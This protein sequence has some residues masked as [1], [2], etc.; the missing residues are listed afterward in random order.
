MFNSIKKKVS[1]YIKSPQLMG[2]PDRP[3]SAVA[4]AAHEIMTTESEKAQSIEQNAAI[5]SSAANKIKATNEKIEKIKYRAQQYTLQ[6]SIASMKSLAKTA[7]AQIDSPEVLNS[8]D[9]KGKSNSLNAVNSIV[10]Q[11]MDTNNG[12]IAGSSVV[13]NGKEYLK[14]YADQI[15]AQLHQHAI[16]KINRQATDDAILNLNKTLPANIMSFKAMHY[17]A[18]DNVK[19]KKEVAEQIHDQLKYVDSLESS[20]RT[21][22]QRFSLEQAKTKLIHANNFMNSIDQMETTGHQVYDRY[23]LELGTKAQ[24]Q[25]AVQENVAMGADPKTLVFSSGG[26]AFANMIDADKT[27]SAYQKMKMSKNVMATISNLA[28]SDSSQGRNAAKLY[29]K[30]IG[31]GKGLE[32]LAS[33]NPSIQ[34]NIDNIR[35]AKTMQ[36]VATNTSVIQNA[37]MT[38]NIPETSISTLLPVENNTLNNIVTGAQIRD[39]SGK[40]TGIDMNTIG[41]DDINNLSQMTLANSSGT[42]FGDTPQANMAKYTRVMPQRLENVGGAV[43]NIF[44]DKYSAELNSISFDPKIQNFASKEHVYLN[45]DGKKVIDNVHDLTS[46]TANIMGNDAMYNLSQQAIVTG[47]PRETLARQMATKAILMTNDQVRNGK[48]LQDSLDI[49]QTRN[50]G[51]ALNFP[52]YSGTSDGVNITVSPDVVQNY[53]PNVTDENTATR[54]LGAAGKEAYNDHVKEMTQAQGIDNTPQGEGEKEGIQQNTKEYA[55]PLSEMSLISQNGLLK[56]ISPSGES[57][58]ITHLDIAKSKDSVKTRKSLLTES[59]ATLVSKK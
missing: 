17:A 49:I 30:M 25:K 12:I 28:N 56:L 38:Y 53:L 20:A 21:P 22:E 7:K 14:N 5:F 26:N 23:N 1:Q 18:G 59:A 57:I 9:N 39:A 43:H 32:L 50:R 45:K 13:K 27:A 16:I 24:T 31:S 48:T 46:L 4:D 54:L 55:Y 33:L 47:I 29:Q 6:N 8:K 40:I 19:A 44:A 52:V 51:M 2:E 15:T 42:V 37:S 35:T 10:S 11:L 34:K 3:T 58:I 36:D 41:T